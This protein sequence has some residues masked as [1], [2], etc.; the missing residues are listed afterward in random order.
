MLN[1][2]R[3]NFREKPYLRFVLMA[4]AAAM[5]LSLGYY[6]TSD[7]SAAAGDWVAR[8]DGV[9]IPE[10][11]FRDRARQVEERYREFLGENF[12]TLSE[13]LHGD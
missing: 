7:G 11:Q 10:W 4:V 13:Q 9:E 3:E 2:L 8:V 5:V 6:F 1:V 12:D